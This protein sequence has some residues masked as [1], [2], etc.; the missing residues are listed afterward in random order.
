MNPQQKSNR[1][2]KATS[3]YLLQHAYNPVDWYEWSEEALTKAKTEDKPI[4]V[5]IGYSSCH[6]CHVMERESFENETIASVMNEHFICIK[7]DREE[8][9]DV[10]HLYM[11]AV[12]AMGMHGGWPLHVFLTPDQKPFYGG[13]YFPPNTWIQVLQNVHQTFLNK[14][15]QVEQSAD[16]LT[17]HLQ[18][19]LLH[20]FKGNDKGEASKMLQTMFQTLQSRFDFTNGGTDKAPKF[21]MPSVWRWLLRYYYIS[22]ETQALNHTLFTL[23]KIARGGIFDQIGGG[24]AR[25]SV[26]AQWFAPHFEKMLYDN[27]QLLSLYSEA[28]RIQPKPL[29]QSVMRKTIDWLKREMFHP[30]GGFYSALDADSEGVEGKF[31]TWTASEL[32][33]I[34]QSDYE[35]LSNYYNVTELGNWEHGVNILKVDIAQQ[36]FCKQYNLDET[37]FD[38]I[39]KRVN[40]KLLLARNNRIKPGLDDKILTG[41]NAM[42]IS[43]LID[44]YYA[45][46]DQEIFNLALNNA[47]F[48]KKHLM[49]GTKLFRS[50]KDKP[51]ATP[52]FLEDYAFVI[53]AWL[54]LYEATF[55]ESWLY[56]AANLTEFVLQEFQDNDG[57]FL[58]SAKSSEQLIANKKEIFD[59]VIPASNGIM[60]QNLFRL[61]VVLE[62]NDWILLATKLITDLSNI[63]RDEPHYM[64]N[65]GIA[66][67][68]LHHALAEVAISGKNAVA[69]SHKFKSRFH[70]LVCMA[71]TTEQSILPVLKGR[72]ASDSTK[73]Y[74]C[75]DKTCQ[76]PVED[77][78]SA[79]KQLK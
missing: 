42:M 10:D 3:P 48:I 62:R 60:C 74:V 43:G 47:K 75:Y 71:G 29:F 68:E 22:K 38:I 67:L 79:W 19:E 4:V 65:W 21:I 37:E 45:L 9:P 24:F 76:L 41:W 35:L 20:Q 61:G 32:K 44:A 63:I 55:D 11:D 12:Q 18:R 58:F 6:W 31:Y 64:S 27:A 46:Q 52:G 33:E 77:V 57:Y 40:E 25:Y 51:S 34:L 28:Y 78:E 69:F 66:W 5:S 50:W 14:R 56:E 1:L 54:N 72:A 49:S 13:T 17:Q 30:N 8:R 39:L 16:D 36:E 53:Q 73:I 2:I 7:V 23:Q 59:N 70:P 15:E 26:D